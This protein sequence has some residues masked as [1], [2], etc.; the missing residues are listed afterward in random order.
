[1]T[2]YDNIG[3]GLK[4][5]KLDKQ[6]RKKKVAEMAEILSIGHVLNQYP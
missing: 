2:V 3:Y 4:I 1:M 6:K 5:Q